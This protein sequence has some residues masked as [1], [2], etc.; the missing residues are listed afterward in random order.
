MRVTNQM[1]SKSFLRDLSKNQSYMMKL[2]NQLTSGKEISRP[3][4]NPYKVARSMQ[5]SSDI[6]TAKQ[7]NE[8]IK[9]TTNWLDTTDTSIQQLEK[10]IQRVRELMVSAGNASYG[11]DEKRAI[12]DEIN[13]K[14]NEISQILNTT[15]D[16]KYIF[17]GTKVN[18][19]PVAT[20]VVDGKSSLFISGKLGKK[21]DLEKIN[22]ELEANG[23][24]LKTLTEKEFDSLSDDLKNDISEYRNIAS[25]L[26]VEVSQGV[27]I[28]YNVS[29]TEILSFKGKDGETVDVMSLLT[30]ITS[31]LDSSDEKDQALV[32]GDNLSKIDETIS[33]LL[34]LMS[35][36]GAKQNRMES[37]LSQND[38]Q[39]YN[40]KD[41]LSQTEDIDFAEKTIEV[42]VAQSVYTAALQVSA[43]IVQQ[44]LLDFL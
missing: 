23:L 31:N 17:G 13:E 39:I 41:I 6:A 42:T 16:G 9:D 15:F 8:N 22:E 36:V 7:Y 11:S 21:I 20:E 29:A 33:N 28:K 26:N 43:N 44:T 3:S 24:N 25:S 1:M 2:N 40:L 12:K 27:S 4:D 34:K 38:E 10:S 19:K 37:A 18:T 14:V 5:L 30:E 35:E 32:I